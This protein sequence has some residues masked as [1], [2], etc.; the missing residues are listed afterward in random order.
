MTAEKTSMWRVARPE[1][2]NKQFAD[3]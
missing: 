2:E 3:N 1:R